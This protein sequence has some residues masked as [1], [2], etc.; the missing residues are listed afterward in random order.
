MHMA[1]IDEVVEIFSL[2]K[3]CGKCKSESFCTQLSEACVN[4]PRGSGVIIL[5]SSSIYPLL[6]HVNIVYCT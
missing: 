6:K 4:L 5:D 3:Y 1:Q 2:S